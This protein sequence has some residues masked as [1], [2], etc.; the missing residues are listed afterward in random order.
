MQ[1]LILQFF[2]LPVVFSLLSPTIFLEH[3]LLNTL[4]LWSYNNVRDQ[5]L[6]P[7]TT[8]GIIIV[9]YIS[10]LVFIDSKKDDKKF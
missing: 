1:L 3:P 5:V 6:H 7:Y 2:E 4:S 10:V 9:L 8:K